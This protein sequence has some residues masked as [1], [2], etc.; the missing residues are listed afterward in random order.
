M[1]QRRLS[2]LFTIHIPT[3]CI[4][5]IGFCSLAMA[6]Q[7]PELSIASSV[8][9]SGRVFI[10]QSVRSGKSSVQSSSAPP[11]SK[12]KASPLIPKSYKLGP[13]DS[14]RITVKNYPEFDQAEVVIPPDGKVAIPNFGTFQV[15]GKTREQVQAHLNAILAKQM[16]NP[17]ITVTMVNL[18]PVGIGQVY[19]VGS[20]ATPGTVEIQEGFRLT[21][22]LAAGGGVQGSLED[23]KATLTR[24]GQEPKEIDLLEAVT[25]PSS[26]AN[27]KL[28][29]GDVLTLINQEAPQVMVIGAVGRPGV[30]KLRRVPQVG[31]AELSLQA[32]VLDAIVAAGSVQ[33]RSGEISG[34]LTR[35][36]Q[37]NI[38]LDVSSILAQPTSKANVPLKPGDVLT[39]APIEP[40]RL[41]ITGAVARPSVYELHQAPTPNALELSLAP[42]LSDA[43]I[44]AGGLQKPTSQ[45]VTSAGAAAQTEGTLVKETVNEIRFKGFVQRQ[46]QRIDLNVM[47]VLDDPDSE[48][49]ITLLPNDFVTI[50]AVIPPPPLPPLTIFV[51]GYIQRPGALQIERGSKVFQAITQAGGLTQPIEKIDA[52]LRRGNEIM[53]LDLNAVML[54]ADAQANIQLQAGDVLQLREPPIIRVHAAGSFARPGAL[55]LSPNANLL[56]AIQQ[57]GGLSIKP[58]DARLNI[59]RRLNDGGQQVLTADA[60]SLLELRDINQNVLLK[61]GDL[62]NVTPKK[63]QTV[64][65]S[66]EV[67]R[68]G[69][70]DIKEGEGLPAL[71]TRAGGATPE[72]AT[73]KIAVQRADKTELVDAYAALKEGKTL[74]FPLQEGDYIVV[75]EN[76]NRVLIMEAVAKPGYYTIPDKGQLTLLDALGQAGGPNAKTK[77]VVL[78]RQETDGVKRQIIALEQVRSGVV[79]LSLQNGDVL[80]VPAGK[81]KAPLLSTLLSTLGIF[82]ILVP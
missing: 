17:Q 28:Q 73:T 37:E 49:N 36:G 15:T 68:P 46:G 40:A 54:D 34:I 44:A 77:E 79:N 22:V 66:G 16:R 45:F 59:L 7:N 53:L 58:E 60:V 11:D 80:Y 71:I 70:Y 69:S 31:A 41:Y 78:L 13:K 6:N 26:N 42:R 23:I 62:I 4:F 19:I 38:K 3:C 67:A 21:E 57:A 5:L 8:E 10:A 48:A 12:A 64:F 30:F 63:S 50:E 74:D 81:V 27:Q 18:R 76:K 82:R 43:I 1:K 32:N 24:P 51:D 25:H 72:A 35:S 47:K 20:V 2:R 61:E 33:G 39:F 9:K 52:S 75:P 65:I 14:F 29:P 55:R 56:E